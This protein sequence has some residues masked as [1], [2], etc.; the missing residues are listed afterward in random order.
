MVVVLTDVCSSFFFLFLFLLFALFWFFADVRIITIL[1]APSF[2]LTFPSFT[3]ILIPLL[4]FAHSKQRRGEWASLS[5]RIG[6]THKQ[7]ASFIRSANIK[8]GKHKNQRFVFS[9]CFCFFFPYTAKVSMSPFVCFN[10]H[11]FLLTSLPISFFC[12]FTAK[13][14]YRTHTQDVRVI[15]SAFCRYSFVFGCPCE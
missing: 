2:F 14:K 7:G 10:S 3:L 4:H 11:F 8:T 1:L 9:L 5:V 6:S 12:L 15:A 13:L